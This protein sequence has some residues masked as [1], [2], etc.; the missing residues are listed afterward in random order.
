MRAVPA[1]LRRCS[2]PTFPMAWMTCQRTAA[3]RRR[4]W[5][6]LVG[7]AT[8]GVLGLEG[9]SVPILGYPLTQAGMSVVL[10]AR[11]KGDLASYYGTTRAALTTFPLDG[12]MSFLF[13]WVVV[14]NVVWLFR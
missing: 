6:S 9:W 10:L 3:C 2:G 11:C 4:T 7:G 12:L 5:S 1:P 8:C 13:S 14:H